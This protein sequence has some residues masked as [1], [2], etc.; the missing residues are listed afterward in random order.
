MEWFPG[1]DADKHKISHAIVWVKFP[2][3]TVEFWIEKTL[4]ALRKTLGTPI[5]VDKRTLAHE[6]GHFTSV[7]IDINFAELNTDAIHVTVGGLDFW[8]SFE[9]QKKPKFCSKCKLIGHSD[10]ECRK[11]TKKNANILQTQSSSQ[12]QKTQATNAANV[13]GNV[14]I[15]GSEWKE[16]GRK[17]K[18]KN[19]LLIPFVPEIVNNVTSDNQANAVHGQHGHLVD[20]VAVTSA[21]INLEEGEVVSVDIQLQDELSRSEAAANSALAELARTKLKVAERAT[22]VTRASVSEF[23]KPKSYVGSEA[24]ESRI[25]IGDMTV[26]SSSGTPLT[27]NLFTREC[28]VSLNQFESLN[29]ELGLGENSDAALETFDTSSGRW[30]NQIPTILSRFAST[31]PLRTGIPGLGYCEWCS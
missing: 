10:S 2:C 7:L 15:G 26:D 22:L 4:L 31:I 8:Q 6:Y 21:D 14:S 12:G 9:I 29:N 18:G 1:F 16:V 30:N 25:P 13:I 28:V 11:K 17:K 3:L 19:A 20:A 23:P 5:V 27:D 24:R